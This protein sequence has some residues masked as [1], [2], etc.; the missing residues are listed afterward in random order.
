MSRITSLATRAAAVGTALAALCGVG[1][2]TA[3][4]ETTPAK[5]YPVGGVLTALRNYALTPGQVAG[6]NDWSCKPSKEH[7]NPVV[8]A[9]GTF[10][11]LGSN[12]AAIAP[13]LANQGYCVYALNYGMDPVISL[14]R[15]GG[16]TATEES[17]RQLQTFVDKVLASTGARKVDVVGH[18]QGG[19][20]ANYYIKRLGGAAKVRTYIGMAPNNHGTT[21]SGLS[22]LADKLGV[23]GL[24]RGVL[25]LARM[26]GV[27]DQ[28]NDSDFIKDLSSDPDTVPGVRY[29]VIAT[30]YDKVVTPYQSQFLDGPGVEN[31]TIQDQ[32]PSD[33]V[34]HIGLFNDGP[35]IQNVLNILGPDKADFQPDCEDYGL[36]L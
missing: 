21:F 32:C 3:Q 6:A 13:T 8:L 17:G 18:S 2:G 34:G 9:H 30:R 31:I 22:T 10:F 15:I 29:A 28:L 35:T 14:N 26:P 4:A 24:V 36:P 12:W 7:P 5:T 19:V 20:L 16:L 23:L 27:K 25:D 1:I 33:P 11:N